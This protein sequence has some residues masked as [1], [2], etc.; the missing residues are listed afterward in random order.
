MKDER[1]LPPLPEE[2]PGRPQ[3]ERYREQFG[4]I[5]LCADEGEHKEVYEQL[6]SLG[7]KCRVVRT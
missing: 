5:V 6:S 2:A 4:V 3:A 1:M 7:F